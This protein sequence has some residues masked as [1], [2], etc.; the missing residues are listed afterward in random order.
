M[1]VV[2][3]LVAMA[4]VAIFVEQIGY[5]LDVDFVERRGVALRPAHAT[6]LA[7]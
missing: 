7:E 3:A 4:L 2:E 1:P 5:L 6:N